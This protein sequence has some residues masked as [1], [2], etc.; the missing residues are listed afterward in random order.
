LKKGET[1]KKEKANETKTT[2]ATTMVEEEKPRETMVSIISL[3]YIYI[4]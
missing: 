4:F 1:G 3:L 2:K